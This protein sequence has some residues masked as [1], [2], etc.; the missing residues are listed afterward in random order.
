[1]KPETKEEKIKDMLNRQSL[2]IGAAPITNTYLEEV[3]KKMIDRGVLDPDQ[4]K[5]DRKQRTIKS[6]L[7]SWA[8]KHL[9]I[10]D[11]EWDTIKLDEIY[12]TYS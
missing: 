1:M 9:K 6:V 11:A 5:A 3:K 12:Q 8:F 2:V 7:K 10:S 4:P